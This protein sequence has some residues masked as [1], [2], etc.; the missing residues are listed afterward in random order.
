MDKDVFSG[1]H[2]DV[3]DLLPPEAIQIF[4]SYAHEDQAFRDLLGKH[5]ASLARIGFVTQWYDGNIRAGAQWAEEIYQHLNTADIILLLVSPDFMHSDFC[6][7]VEM[8]QALKRHQSGDARV[9]PILLRHTYWEQTPIGAL[10]GSPRGGKPINAW[11]N[12]DQAFFYVVRDLLEEIKL[13]LSQRWVEKSKIF[14]DSQRDDYALLA[15]EKAILLNPLNIPAYLSKGTLLWHA[16]R[17]EEA[18]STYKQIIALDPKNIFAHVSE[19]YALWTLGRYHE[20]LIA[21]DQILLLD[22]ENTIA[23][24]VKAHLYTSLRDQAYQKAKQLGFRNKQALLN[25]GHPI[26]AELLYT[27]KEQEHDL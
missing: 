8:T 6:Y 1:Q 12:R 7:H 2:G 11:R 3:I 24:L 15:C 27:L 14:H 9:L 21:C 16:R 13:L 23:Y 22:P 17:Y 4:I 25:D 26:M 5:L 19:T 10:R 18:L 20:A